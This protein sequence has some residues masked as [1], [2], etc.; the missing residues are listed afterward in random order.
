MA[1]RAGYYMSKQ[2]GATPCRF[3]LTAH[4]LFS[5]CDG[6]RRGASEGHMLMPGLLRRART[7][8]MAPRSSC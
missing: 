6:P 3:S 4:A 5:V 2:R 8:R 7:W 1:K